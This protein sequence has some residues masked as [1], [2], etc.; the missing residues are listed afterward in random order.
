MTKP[1]LLEHFSKKYP[2][3]FAANIIYDSNTRLP[4]GYG[5]VQFADRVE[6]DAAIKDLDGTFLRGRAIKVRE[7][8]TRT[9]NLRQ[10]HFSRG[11]PKSKITRLIIFKVMGMG[12][13]ECQEEV[14][15]TTTPPG[16]T[17][18]HRAYHQITSVLIT[19]WACSSLLV[20]KLRPR[21]KLCS[22]PK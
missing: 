1:I 22:K 20:L 10:N 2:S 19:T 15:W 16:D 11:P 4:K 13:K 8:Y 7:S 14:R 6:A 18:T 3:A 21:L 5:F 17:R 12:V 9:V